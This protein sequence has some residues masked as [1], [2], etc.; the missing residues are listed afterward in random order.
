MYKVLST[1]VVDIDSYA[2]AVVTAPWEVMEYMWNDRDVREFHPINVLSMLKQIQ[3]ISTGDELVKEQIT[4]WLTAGEL[5]ED[6]GISYDNMRGMLIQNYK[7]YYSSFRYFVAIPSAWCT[8]D[9]YLFR[10]VYDISDD[11]KIKESASTLSLWRKRLVRVCDSATRDTIR[12]LLKN[13][14]NLEYTQ[15]PLGPARVLHTDALNFYAQNY[16]V[17]RMLEHGMPDRSV[18]YR[19]RIIKDLLGLRVNIFD[20]INANYV[21]EELNVCTDQFCDDLGRERIEDIREKYSDMV[22]NYVAKPWSY[23][24]IVSQEDK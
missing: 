12:A 9:E 20:G 2:K 4:N 11:V 5:A 21:L 22:I 1:D 6:Y 23:D 8:D 7:F 15:G 16:T 13:K 18:N 24:G 17:T 19:W 10:I 14:G 3:K